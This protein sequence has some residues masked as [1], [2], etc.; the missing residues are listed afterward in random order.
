MRSS[1]SCFAMVA[2]LLA[3]CDRLPGHRTTTT[4]RDVEI[5]PGTASDEM[6]TLDQAAGDGTAVDQS[7]A[8]GPVDHSASAAAGDATSSDAATSDNGASADG[9][10]ASADPGSTGGADGNDAAPPRPRASTGDAAKP[11]D[12]VIRPPTRQPSTPAR[13]PATPAPETK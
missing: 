11:G 9:G 4:M 6:V 13:R 10:A 2:L 12:T 7:M 5:L 1:I 8:V 3:G